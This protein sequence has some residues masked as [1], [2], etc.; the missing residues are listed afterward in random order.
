MRT[1]QRLAQAGHM[2]A[3]LI[4]I[5]LSAGTGRSQISHGNPGLRGGE[6]VVA[7]GGLRFGFL[8]GRKLRSASLFTTRL[9]LRMAAAFCQSGAFF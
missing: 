7:T 2:N 4:K 5:R 1:L 3:L 9:L 6:G 8:G